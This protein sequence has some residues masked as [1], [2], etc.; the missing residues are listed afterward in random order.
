MSDGYC[1]PKKMS[2]SESKCPIEEESEAHF[3]VH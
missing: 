1:N 2:V 3:S